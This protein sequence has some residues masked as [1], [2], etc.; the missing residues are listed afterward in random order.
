MMSTSRW[1]AAMVSFVA[2]VLAF[3]GATSA[4][5]QPGFGGRGQRSQEQGLG[6]GYSR[7]A[8]SAHGS[9]SEV[10]APYGM[11]A[12]SQPLAVQVGIDILKA[13]GN[14]I[15][16]SVAVNAMLGLVEPHMNGV[17]GDLF[18]ILMG[19]QDG[20]AICAERDGPRPV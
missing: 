19:C 18:A 17:G 15:D 4:A 20:E 1:R 11:V 7:P 5:R 8:R 3:I 9:R 10:I 2:V 6:S 12:A 14:A 13:G 16:A